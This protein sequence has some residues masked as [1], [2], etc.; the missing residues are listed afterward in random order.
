MF[1]RERNWPQP[2]EVPAATV[3]LNLP[4]GN[5]YTFSVEDAK[6]VKEELNRIFGPDYLTSP[7]M[8]R[9]DLGIDE[10]PLDCRNQRVDNDR[11]DLPF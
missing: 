2:P 7:E 10:Y 11:D 8:T 1:K 6:I 4:S 5:S 3:T 9:P